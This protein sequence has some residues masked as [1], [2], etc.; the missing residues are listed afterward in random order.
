MTLPNSTLLGPLAEFQA[1][2]GVPQTSPRP[3]GSQRF[4]PL[5][6]R[7][8]ER[9][10][11]HDGMC[12]LGF[13]HAMSLR[14]LAPQ[15]GTSCMSSPPT[16]R[17]PRAAHLC[18]THHVTRGM[19]RASGAKWHHPK[20]AVPPDSTLDAAEGAMR[21]VMSWVA[22]GSGAAAAAGG[23]SGL[24]G[25]YW[26]VRFEVPLKL[27]PLHL[28]FALYHPGEWGDQGCPGG[29]VGEEAGVLS[30]PQRLVVRLECT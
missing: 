14:T 10:P 6:M 28:A 4:P 16:G 11:S 15:L 12:M 19:Y 5:T 30:R 1:L 17:R 29:D 25:G 27:A 22:P 13:H 26:T 2:D 18:R 8:Q 23:G 21:T 7:R 20:E 3:L 24:R 9:A